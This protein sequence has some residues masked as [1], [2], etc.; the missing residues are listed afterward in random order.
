VAPAPST[1]L[2]F[3]HVI[4]DQRLFVEPAPKLY[5]RY[6]RPAGAGAQNAIAVSD[7]VPA[8]PLAS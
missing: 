4:D 5:E 3:G 2:P 6:C 1:F 8:V 7:Q